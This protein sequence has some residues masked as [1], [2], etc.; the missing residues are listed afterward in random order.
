MKSPRK[1]EGACVWDGQEMAGS[2]RWTIELTQAEIATLD[3]AVATAKRRGTPWQELTRESF[4][5]PGL[6]E[7]LAAARAELEEGSGM[8]KLRRI[9]VERYEPADLKRLW[10]GLGLHLGT[11]RFQ[12]ARG[13]LMREI[14]D[15]GAGIGE[16]YGAVETD[17]GTFLSSYARTLSN[18]ALRFHTD[19]CDVVGLLCVSQAGSGGVSTLCSSAAV[20]NRILE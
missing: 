9:P 13:E 16:R 18:G 2:D 4:A 14:C 15:E 17:K 10:Y 20:H 5:L 1:I 19:R 6:E 8:V 7:R 3:A 11:P 12:N